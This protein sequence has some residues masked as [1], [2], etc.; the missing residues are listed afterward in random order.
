MIAD[1]W[2]DA[3]MAS[4]LPV[5]NRALRLRRDRKIAATEP[6]N[7]SFDFDYFRAEWTFLGTSGL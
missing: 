4:T 1:I 2:T 6:T 7:T 3:L 5:V